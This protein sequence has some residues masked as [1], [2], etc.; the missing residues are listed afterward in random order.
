MAKSSKSERPEPALPPARV[1]LHA[2]EALEALDGA[3]IAKDLGRFAPALGAVRRRGDPSSGPGARTFHAELASARVRDL[4]LPDE[5]L[6]ATSEDL[7]F[8]AAIDAAPE[9]VASALLAKRLYDGSR[10]AA[11]AMSRLPPGE[12]TMDA[13]HLWVTRRFLLTYSKD[14][15]RYHAR[16]AVFGY[17]VVVSL[18][19]LGLAPA[20]SLEAALFARELARRGADAGAIEAEL[21]LQY[22][23]EKV[24]I[25]DK[26]TVS[27]AV[28]S[29]VLQG[30]SALSGRSAFCKDPAC[31]LFNPHRK[32]EMRRSILGGGMCAEHRAFFGQ[33]GKGA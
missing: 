8:E 23:D 5:F 1:F 20:P 31:R 29:A 12:R 28:A 27:A 33:G 24:D 26:A 13:L 22:P 4:R 11:C 6:P 7:E 32:L 3:A 30:A 19:G 17:P 2:S 21:D 15:L 25:D 14:D 18:L 16:Y 9:Q 10:V